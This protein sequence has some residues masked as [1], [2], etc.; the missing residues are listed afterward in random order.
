MLAVSLLAAVLWGPSTKAGKS[1][2][3]NPA[4]S[5]SMVSATQGHLVETK[6]QQVEWSGTALRELM[7]HGRLRGGALTNYLAPTPLAIG[8]CDTAMPVEVE[9]GGATG[10]ATL[11]AAFAAINAGTHTGA[12]INIEIC[13]NPAEGVTPAVLNASGTGSA[14]YTNIFIKPVGGAART[15]TGNPAGGSPLIDLNG[16]DNVTI[17]GLNT[18]S[19]S[20]TISNTTVSTTAQTSTIRLINGA[21]N[22][23][24]RNT[25][26]TGVATGLSTGVILF[27]NNVAGNGNNDNNTIDTC[28][29]R[30]GATTPVNGVFALGPNG[31][32]NDNNTITDSN[33]FNFSQ[34]TVDAAGIRLTGGN[35]DW[36]ITDNSFYQTATR[37]GTASRTVR[38]ILIDNSSGN[39]FTITGN[40]IGGKAP[41]AGGTAWEITG[42]AANYKFVGIQLN[43]GSTTASSVQNNTIKNFS[44][45]HSTN[46]S[47]SLPGISGRDSCTSRHNEYWHGDGQHDWRRYRNRI[48]HRQHFRH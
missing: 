37:T 31:E 13:G 7:V 4:D 17:D 14:S 19:N 3:L 41:L 6:G 45:L 42:T 47:S 46:G 5:R 38:G 1:T 15:I 39:E 36:E 34:A 25:T 40:F 12:T 30:D 29:I 32:E 23:T 27:G 18:G 21:T 11:G 33:I 26:V 28:N 20:L 16:A 48:Y 24:I 44:W 2:G 43:V 22:N 10:Y 8:T 9:A 35:T